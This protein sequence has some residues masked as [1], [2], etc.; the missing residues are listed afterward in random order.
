MRFLGLTLCLLASTFG[1][2]AD[3]LEDRVTALELRVKVLEDTLRT[4]VGGNAASANIDGTYKAA[5]PNGSSLTATFDKGKVTVVDGAKTTTATYAV[6]GGKVFVTGD[7]K[8]ESLTV[9]GDHLRTE[10]NKHLDFQNRGNPARAP[11][12]K[13]MALMKPPPRMEDGEPGVSQRQSRR[14]GGK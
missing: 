3:S 7:G 5:L 11:H 14:V 2:R 1:A 9:D 8:T 10:D 6:A 4:Q 13:W 12:R